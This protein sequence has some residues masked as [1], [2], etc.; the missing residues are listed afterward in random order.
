MTGDHVTIQGAASQSGVSAKMI[1]HYEEIGLIPPPM[2]GENRYRKYD[3]RLIHELSFIHQARMLGF[4][5]HDIKKLLAL[6]RDKSRTSAEVKAIALAH[7]KA[8]DEKAAALRRMS[9]SLRDLA[10]HCQGNHRPD[11]PILDKLAFR[12]PHDA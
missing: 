10:E 6:W 7:I 3:T 9:A 11:C 2:R 12:N 1:R 8:L 5:I 4:S